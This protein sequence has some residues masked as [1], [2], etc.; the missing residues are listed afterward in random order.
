MKLVHS[1]TIA[2]RSEKVLKHRLFPAS[3]AVEAHRF[4]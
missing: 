2:H 3:E 4:W 1:A